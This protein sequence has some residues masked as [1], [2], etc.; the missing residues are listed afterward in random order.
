MNAQFL[1]SALEGAQAMQQEA[2]QLWKPPP[3]SKP[4]RKEMVLPNAVVKDSHHYLKVIVYQINLTYESACYDAC[5]VL[6]RRL[7]ETLIIE[8]FE[9][10]GIADKL[11]DAGGD[12]PYLKELI[13]HALSETKW[14]MGRNAKKALPKLK[15]I[16]DLAAHS[17]R[18]NAYRDDIDRIRDDL[19]L[20]V[21]ELLG[22]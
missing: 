5:A 21:Q 22:L 12:F 20:V 10:H 17:R 16:G 14:N 8:A 11:K 6:I 7:V 19:R 4:S 3:V 18:F 15:D 9:R 1:K 13:K 2:D